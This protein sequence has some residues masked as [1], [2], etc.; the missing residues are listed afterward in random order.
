MELDIKRIED[1]IILEVANKIVGND[2]L[3]ARVKR[4]TDERINAHF[5]KTGDAQIRAAI[6]AAINNCFEHEY[7]RIDSFGRREGEPTTVKAELERMIAG[8][9][10]AKV[11]RDGKE[12]SSSYNAIT[13]AEW[14]MANLVASDFQGE[15]KQHVVNLGGALKDK[16]R[17][18]LHETVN[19]ILSELVRVNSFGDQELKRGDGSSIDP[20]QVPRP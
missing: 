18:Q 13:R 3:Y 14:L 1:A 4:A 20:K 17:E 16:L 5:I 10:N 7:C 11:G 9:W 19:K 15:M 2:D 6:E 8:Y 12:T